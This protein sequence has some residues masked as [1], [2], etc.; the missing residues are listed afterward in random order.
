MDLWRKS[1]AGMTWMAGGHVAVRAAQFAIG[2]FLARLL[3]PADFGIV[4]MIAVFIGVSEMFV[5]CGFPLAFMRKVDRTDDDA[6]TVFWF[7]LG[8]S[9]VCYAALFAAAPCIA[10]FFGEPGLVPVTRVVTTGI[11]FGALMAV[12]RALLKV[13]LRFKILSVL[14]IFSVLVSGLL[15]VVLASRGYGVWALIWQGVLGNVFL[16]VSM[17]MAA[18]WLPRFVFSVESFRGFFSFGWKHLVSSLVNAVYYHV[19]SLVAGK[20]LGAAA[21]GIY[22]RAHSWASLPP[23]VVSEAMTNV[24]YPILS[25]IQDDNAALRRAYDRLALVSVALL[26]PSLGFLAAFAEPVVRLVLGN[27]WLCCVPYIRILAVGSMFEPAMNLYQNMLYLKGRTDI[28][29]KLEFLQK[30]VCFV[31][32][33]AGL[34]FGLAG[35]CAA[36]SASTV[37][38]A[39][40]NLVAARRV[41]G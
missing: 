32:V 14:G 17:T 27:Q 33:F 6:A 29:M 25:A 15:G 21:V 1:L 24:N 22:N 12:P 31:L 35:L 40:V 18:R 16:L 3:T 2:I 23:Q 37:F 8:V 41:A 4:G 20:A 10:T 30:P 28:V 26:I 38:M 19:Y 13:R 11:I 39:A 34:P 9:A 7:S 36:R 5:D